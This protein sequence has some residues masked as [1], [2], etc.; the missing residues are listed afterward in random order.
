MGMLTG[1]LKNEKGFSLIEVMA[2]VAMIVV[3]MSLVIPNITKM[4]TR[5]REEADIV[6]ANAIGKAVELYIMESEDEDL[7]S[8]SQEDV[9]KEIESRGYVKKVGK[10]KSKDCSWNID[11]NDDGQVE[12]GIL[13]DGQDAKKL[14]P[15]D[16]I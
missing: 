4:N 14:Y 6:S 11:I 1:K 9:I 2:A 15:S 8:K 13:K 7:S 3:L 12:V 5:G 10:P 16:D